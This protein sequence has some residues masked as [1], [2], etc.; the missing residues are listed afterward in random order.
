MLTEIIDQS[1]GGLPAIVWDDSEPFSLEDL[2][3]PVEVVSKDQD[4]NVVGR[5]LL[6]TEEEVWDDWVLDAAEVR[7]DLL[8]GL[9]TD[10]E[11]VASF[12]R[13][14]RDELATIPEPDDDPEGT[15]LLIATIRDISLDRGEGEDG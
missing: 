8:R 14:A 13:L 3:Y 10:Y 4:G 6:A 15:A 12:I 2:T 11:G 9:E 1:D 5:R 7:S